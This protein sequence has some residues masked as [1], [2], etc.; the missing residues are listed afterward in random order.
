MDTGLTT[1]CGLILSGVT[2]KA[3]KQ[4]EA[5]KRWLAEHP[6]YRRQWREKNLEKCRERSRIAARKWRERHPDYAKEYYRRNARIIAVKTLNAK[7]ADPEKFR[8]KNRRYW[9]SPKGRAGFLL[10][11]AKDRSANVTITKQWIQERLD[12]GCCEVTGL[13][14][15]LTANK[16]ANPWS[17]SLDQIIPGKGY[18]P[19]NTQLV[20]WI[21]NVAKGSW[22]HE[23]V[24]V[25]A[26][27]LLRVKERIAA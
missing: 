7:R 15:V 27:A 11:C 25:F 18:T 2:M 19:E 3:E 26:D 5:T 17:P 24:L 14:F 12:R 21:Y 1:L 13:P 22:V 10:R 4:K 9:T 23:D 16:I 8:E 6:E 20:V